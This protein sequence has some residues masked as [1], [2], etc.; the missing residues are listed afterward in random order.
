MLEEFKKVVLEF[1]GIGEIRSFQLAAEELPEEHQSA[2]T[3]FAMFCREAWHRDS[4]TLVI[5]TNGEVA[6]ACYIGLSI[7]Y[8]VRDQEE[9]LPSHRLDYDLDYIMT[10]VGW[11]KQ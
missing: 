2:D 7:W 3:C 11:E 9:P 5:F 4:S 6:L 10:D 8:L 1:A